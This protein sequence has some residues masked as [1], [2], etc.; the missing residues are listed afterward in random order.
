M[1]NLEEYLNNPCKT[2]SIPYWKNEKY[3]KPNHI[4]IYHEH[5]FKSY[6]QYQKVDRFF[7][8]IHHLDHIPNQNLMVETIDLKQDIN[9]LVDM[10]NESYQHENIHVTSDDLTSWLN[11]EVYQKDLWV[12]I[13]IDNQ[14]VASGI[15]EYD[16]EAK[17]G[18]LEW[19]QV[20]P[21]FQKRG[22]GQMIVNELINRLSRQA[23]FVTVSGRLEN[24][25]NP[26]RLYQQCGFTGDDVW[27][28]CYLK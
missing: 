18:I 24:S 14:I 17:E 12:K 4:E 28:I 7:R 6:D 16:D 20:R 8:M 1:I 3:N 15:A 23:R 5:Q 2:L 10:I 27:Y 13:V 26:R 22:F 11:K 25:T 9:D 19:I 21:K